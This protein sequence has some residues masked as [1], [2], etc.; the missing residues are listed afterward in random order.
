MQ[1]HGGAAAEAAITSAERV[2]RASVKVDWNGNGLFDHPLSDLDRYLD[3]VSLDK[4]LTG[5]APEE[6]FLVEGSS[7]AELRLTLNG[8]YDGESLTR[9]FSP[10]NLNSL[11]YGKQTVD[12]EI[13]YTIT[14]ETTEG[15]IS[16]PQ[17]IGNIRT[18]T[19]N[20]AEATVEITALDRA[21][22]MRRP[23]QLPPWAMSDIHVIVGEIDSQLVRSDWV[24]DDACRLCDISVTDKRPVYRSEL[25][26]AQDG[27]DGVHLWVSGTG[28]YLPTI[29]WVDNM[30]AS[31]FPNPGSMMYNDLGPRHRDLPA[32]SPRP[33]GL[34]GVGT[35]IVGGPFGAGPDDR[36]V[37]RYWAA[38]Q[39]Q[40]NADG[41]HYLGFTINTNGPNGD[42]FRTIDRHEVLEIYIG[43]ARALY[44]MIEDGQVWS[45]MR[46]WSD[47]DSNSVQ[48][49]SSR[50][51]IPTGQDHVD[52]FVQWDN[53]RG[54]ESRVYVR[55]GN[56]TNNNGSFQTDSDDVSSDYVKGT[57][58]IKGRISIGH[59]LNLSDI[60]YATGNARTTQPYE[61]ERAWRPAAYAAVLDHGI[62]RFSFIPSTERQE[63]WS[64]VQAVAAAE[65]GSIFWDETGVLRF[66]NWETMLA[67]RDNVV[68]TFSLDHV[69]GLQ[70]TNAIDSVRNVYTIMTTQRR[71]RMGHVIYDS[72][73]PDFFYVPERTTQRFQIWVDDI[74]SPLTW[75]PE[76]Y[77]GAARPFGLPAWSDGV[78]H[79]YVVQYFGDL[80]DGNG[81]IWTER[82]EFP[83]PE[84]STYF[85]SLGNLTVRIRN[86]SDY[87]MRLAL[88]LGNESGRAAFRVE[89]TSILDAQELSL[90][91][92]HS[93]S[94][95]KYGAR[96]WDLNSPWYQDSLTQ[97]RLLDIMLERTSEP[98]PTTDAITVAGDPRLQLGDVIRVTDHAGF[99]DAI[100]LQAYGIN[101][102]FTKDEGLTDTLT[103]EMVPPTPD[104]TDPGNPDPPDPEPTIR[105][106]LCD[107]PSCKHDDDDYYGG[108]GRISDQDGMTRRYGYNT[109]DNAICPKG[110]VKSGL[111]YVA[112]A[113]IKARGG[114]RSGNAS[115]HWYSRR[116]FIESGEE[117]QWSVSTDNTIRVYTKP[118]VAPPGTE[119]MLL[120]IEGIN[121]TVTIGSVLYEE[122]DKERPYFD[123]D[124]PGGAWDGKDGD[125]TSRWLAPE[126]TQEIL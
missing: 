62:N 57:D 27:L 106:N 123:G 84:I 60:Y 67:K 118:E 58:Q 73:D 95:M 16:Y 85:S 83:T 4:A 36:G 88:G 3:A 113:Q 103:V 10:F 91:Y 28:S 26:V 71:A 43:W 7:A 17:F 81:D 69:D 23:I 124:S 121:G 55:A 34:Q 14:V 53:S 49:T 48:A 12:R 109:S 80:G 31:T 104:L 24:I 122:T 46:Y 94:V 76:R 51:A 25:G 86:R 125:S 101:R 65:F 41:I 93:Q 18:I 39:D 30:N 15:L 74:V 77:A 59:A 119:R 70:V 54:T 78:R 99:G 37:I 45:E 112:S 97:T 56:N 6:I 8:E 115:I 50:V 87:P 100:L 32:D 126:F 52:V 20:R 68:R 96:N 21:D 64:L 111:T 38:D 13:V 90:P 63:A 116:G 9:I 66:W 72:N 44:V 108:S 2:L 82:D 120:N 42:A 105:F 75:L 47:D 110:D 102:T 98:Q 5:P 11:F 22:K 35:P 79:G 29:G 114:A 19:P 117:V 89:G 92:E 107:N 40:I 1:T 33:R 61:P